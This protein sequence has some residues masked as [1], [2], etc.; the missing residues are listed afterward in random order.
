MLYPTVLITSEM[1][2][3]SVNMIAPV[4]DSN[5]SDSDSEAEA[6]EAGMDLPED[7]EP[8]HTHH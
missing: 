2:Q 5:D 7:Q 6:M 3:S 8:D 1:L 4:T